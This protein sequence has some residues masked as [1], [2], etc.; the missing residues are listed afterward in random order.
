MNPTIGA[1]IVA[2][3]LGVSSVVHAV[4]P[5]VFE[6]LIPERLPGSPRAWVYATGALEA[7][8]AV[9]LVT[10]QR[11]APA[12]TA[13]TLAG[14][15]VGNWTMAV[16]WQGHPKIS[17]SKKAAAWARLPLQVPLIVWAWRAPVN[18]APV[19]SAPTL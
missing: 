4:R 3:T 9:G 11:W 8:C 1:G 6:P 13:A 5:Q 10:R 17:S 15:W 14:I 16:R 7:G 2:G 18:S 12:L 19:D